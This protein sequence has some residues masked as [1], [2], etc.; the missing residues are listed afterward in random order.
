MT[1][2]TSW[3]HDGYYHIAKGH[4]AEE[5]LEIISRLP[6]AVILSL[7][8]WPRISK[9]DVTFPP[10]TETS[11]GGNYHLKDSF[12]ISACWSNWGGPKHL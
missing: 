6:N 4:H 5:E 8:S 10:V 11:V 3:E 1:R 7:V 12:R 2:M 9:L